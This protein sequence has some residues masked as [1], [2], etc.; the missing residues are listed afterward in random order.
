MLYKLP[1][2]ACLLLLVFTGKSQSAFDIFKYVDQVPPVAAN[3]N[4][5]WQQF[6]PKGKR[7]PF[8][9]YEALLDAQI[10]T[11]TDKSNH[12]SGLLSMLSGRYEVEGR[13]VDFTKIVIAEDV[14]LKNKQVEQ[15]RVFM[16][17]VRDYSGATSWTIDSIRKNEENYGVQAEKM[18]R[19]YQQAAP[20]LIKKL[21]QQIKEM[22]ELLNKKG[23]NAILDNQVQTHKFY[24]QLLEV[25][26]LLLDRIKQVNRMIGGSVGYVA[27][28]Q[29]EVMK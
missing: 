13:R 10:N 25:R 29:A 8:Q 19:V 15:S 3:A 18:I 26:G 23:Y 22:N 21:R 17:I 9:Q 11:L 20:V 14:E 27:A 4:E 6:Y 12:Q 5:A 16:D 7:T 1:L 28:L 2:I 24:I